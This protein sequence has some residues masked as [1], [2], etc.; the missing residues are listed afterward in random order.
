LVPFQWLSKLKTP[1]FQPFYHVVSNEKLPH[2]VNYNYR[3]ISQFEKEL[4]FY[5]KYFKPVSLAE[6]ITIKDSGKKIFHLSFD[7]GLKECAE[8]IAPVL[9]QK[10]IP[11]TFFV[12]TG[13][14]DNQR[15]F[16]KYKASLILNR[17]TETSSPKVEQI[18]KEKNLQGK[19]ILK[20]S[21]LQENILDEV[22][23]ILGIDFNDFLKTQKP[24]LTTQQILKL[25]SDGFSIGAHS[26]SHP[27]FYKISEEE[28]LDEV[29]KS[30][31]WLIEEINPEIKAFSFP[32]TDSGVSLKVLKTLEAEKICDVTF[33]T[34]GI[35]YDELDFHFQ[36]YPVE[37]EGDFMLNL[38]EEFIYFALRK[39][40]GKATVKH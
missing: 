14:V 26:F 5:L 23:G 18:L 10:G 27:E 29:K 9:L 11:A 38:K 15:L 7:D 8:I 4:D 22:A 30:M 17:L 20:A 33:G 31:N 36:R 19:E 12:N 32:F 25:K 13:F 21:I 34:A 40:I 2:I 6:L 1:V 24:Y 37:K 16:H 39:I 3:N 28:Q 35:K